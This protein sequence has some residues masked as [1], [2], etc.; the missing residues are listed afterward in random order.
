MKSADV[1]CARGNGR[2][3]MESSDFR[4]EPVQNAVLNI[5]GWRIVRKD[6]SVLLPFT[7]KREAEK[8][9]EFFTEMQETTPLTT[10]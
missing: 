2:L 1:R 7:Q 6:G 3:R 9:I 8:L 10:D 5:H 4:I